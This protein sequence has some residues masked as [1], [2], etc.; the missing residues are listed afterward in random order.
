MVYLFR[1]LILSFSALMLVSCAG[2]GGQNTSYSKNDFSQKSKAVVVGKIYMQDRNKA[3]KSVRNTWRSTLTDPT[4]PNQQISLSKGP[5]SGG[6]V[7]YAPYVIDS[8]AYTLKSI[9]VRFDVV[10]YDFHMKDTMLHAQYGFSTIYTVPGDVV[11][12]GDIKAEIINGKFIL[13]T[14]D[15][16]DSAKSELQKTHPELARKLKKKLVH[17]DRRVAPKVKRVY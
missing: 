6:S 11:Y 8:G 4:K 5:F 3:I 10:D 9:Q 1:S 7:T 14:I 17:F 2:P 13:E 16:F 15:R 12:I